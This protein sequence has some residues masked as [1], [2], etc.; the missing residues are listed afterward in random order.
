M[1]IPRIYHLAV[2]S[3]NDFI[4]LEDNAAKHIGL[5]LRL[6][7]GDKVIL[8]NGDGCD[9]LAEISEIQK[10]NMRIKIIE[11]IN[12]NPDQDSKL[13]LHL[14]QAI[15]RGEKMDWVIQK[16]V[17]LGVNE[18]TPIITQYMQTKASEQKLEHWKKIIINSCEQCGRNKIPVLYP[19]I[20]LF[21]WL[22]KIKISGETKNQSQNQY[23]LI[24]EPEAAV[25]LSDLKMAISDLNKIK[26]NLLIGPEGG[27]SPDEITLSAQYCFQSV[28]LG[29]RILRT[30]TAAIA[31]ISALQALFG[32]F[33]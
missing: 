31:A 13:S 8:F 24:F 14:G 2:W 21:D 28:K 15:S 3:I 29:N 32:D 16:A 30:E 27:F 1:R 23:N 19:A 9:Y 20:S 12:I 33:R 5:V 6:K 22:N 4:V 26:I 17:E 18:I 11:K 10:K 25:R 7:M